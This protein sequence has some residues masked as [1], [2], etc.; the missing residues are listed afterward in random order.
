[1]RPEDLGKFFE[2]AFDKIAPKDDE[3]REK[4]DRMRGM[5]REMNEMASKSFQDLREQMDRLADSGGGQ[6]RMRELAEEHG[7]IATEVRAA[8]STGFEE[9]ARLIETIAGK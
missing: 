7:R 1:M 9:H 2:E 4:L 6:E 3:H 8:L 5:F